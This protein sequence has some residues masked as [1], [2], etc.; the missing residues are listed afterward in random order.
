MTLTEVIADDLREAAYCTHS[1]GDGDD[2]SLALLK[3]GPPPGMWALT[4]EGTIQGATFYTT[5]TIGK[6]PV[7]SDTMIRM[8]SQHLTGPT[9]AAILP[10]EGWES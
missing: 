4:I 5:V 2:V 9:G 1:H 7:I 3:H 8:S 10:K 6:L